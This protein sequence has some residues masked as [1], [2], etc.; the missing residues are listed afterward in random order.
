MD[1]DTPYEFAG[2]KSVYLNGN[3]AGPDALTQSL[4]TAA[5]QLYAIGLWA[6]ADTSDSFS[7]NFGGT[8]VTGVPTSIAMNGFPR[9]TPLGNSGS[10]TFYSSSALAWPFTGVVYSRPRS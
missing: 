4:N 7:V 6:N 5:G 9:M 8:A 3:F 1:T 2:H 10:F